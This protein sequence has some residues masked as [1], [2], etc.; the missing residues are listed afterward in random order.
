LES[1]LSTARGFFEN[2]L[3]GLDLRQIE[4]GVDDL[5]QMLA[6]HFQAVE[7]PLLLRRQAATADQVGHAGDGI[8][9]RADLVRHVGQ[10]AALRT[11]GCLRRR[12]GLRQFGGARGDLGFQILPVLLQLG[13]VLL[14]LGNIDAHAHDYRLAGIIAG[15]REVRCLD[16]YPSPRRWRARYSRGPN[17]L[18]SANTCWMAR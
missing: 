11:A 17:G 5:Q 4:N 13:L 18:P 7:P 10:E 8:E 15:Y 3:A 6:G 16:P 2:K 1:R 9:R 12:L 14:A